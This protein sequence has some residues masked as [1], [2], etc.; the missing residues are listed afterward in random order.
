MSYFD[1]SYPV[2]VWLKAIHVVAVCFWLCMLSVGLF[3]RSS[4]TLQKTGKFITL[5][6]VFLTFGVVTGVL[7]LLNYN[8]FTEGWLH[9][10]LTLA[11]LAVVCHLV[12]AQRLRSHGGEK[13]FLHPALTFLPFAL[14]AGIVICVV[15][16]P[17]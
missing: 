3:T 6:H 11:T 17:F 13:V 14:F 9:A 15:V 12:I 2:Y 8:S 4:E 10:K 5:S 16:R 1:F 7:L